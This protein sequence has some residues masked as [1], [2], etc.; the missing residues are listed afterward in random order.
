ML[1]IDDSRK[2]SLIQYDSKSG[3]AKIVRNQ[4]NAAPWRAQIKKLL[5][6]FRRD[7]EHP[8]VAQGNARYVISVDD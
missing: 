1:T 5:I 8:T 4:V 7:L 3:Q 2:A 6:Q